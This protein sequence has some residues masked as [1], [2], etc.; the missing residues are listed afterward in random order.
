VDAAID[1]F[2]E[3]LRR[4]PDDAA[5]RESLEQALLYRRSRAALPPERP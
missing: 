2:R 1:E 4:H 5:I 3:T